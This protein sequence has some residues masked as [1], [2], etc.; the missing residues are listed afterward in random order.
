MAA[1]KS[2]SVYV[3]ELSKRIWTE[4]EKF[5]DANIHYRGMKDCL[6]VGMTSLT[7]QK[8]F[9]QHKTG[10]KSKK[11]HKLSA[12]F[13][14]KFGLFL[15]PSLYVGLNPMTRSDAYKM[16]KELAEKLIK[17]GYAVWWN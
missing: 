11:G 4:S 9:K 7:P 12:Y 16:E 3:I 5:R 10:A 1:K 6:Y 17:E 8:R 15:R 13:V 2:H 14:E